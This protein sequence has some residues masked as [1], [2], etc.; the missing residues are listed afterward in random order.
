MSDLRQCIVFRAKCHDSTSLPV[1]SEKRGLQAKRIFDDSESSLFEK[2]NNDVMSL[3]LLVAC[4]GVAM[5]LSYV[6]NDCQKVYSNSS[7]SGWTS[8]ANLFIDD[9]ELCFMA[10]HRIGYLV[11]SGTERARSRY[12]LHDEF[13]L[14]G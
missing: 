5:D 2:I 10:V 8:E 9:V 14:L 7:Y 3:E 11:G 4:L 13:D 6:R 12:G 1:L